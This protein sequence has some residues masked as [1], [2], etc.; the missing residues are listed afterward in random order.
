MTVALIAA[1]SMSGLALAGCLLRRERSARLLPVEPHDA[2][3]VAWG[4]DWAGLVD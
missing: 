4:F 3:E 1:L 2:D